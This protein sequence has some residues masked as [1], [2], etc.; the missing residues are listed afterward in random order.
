MYYLHNFLPSQPDLNFHQPQVRAAILAV[1][2]FWLERGV[3]GFRLDVINYLA[4]DPAL[5]DNP[6][7]G[8]AETPARTYLFQR[9]LHEKSQPGALAFAQSL[10]ALTD[11]YPDRMM[12][13]EIF[14]DDE[15]ALQRAFTE[16]ERRLHTAYSFHLL[17]ERRAEPALF[18]EAL[19][20]WRDASGWP[21]WSIGNHDVPRYP[22]RLGGQGAGEAQV[23]AL[24]AALFCLR[25]TLFLYQGDELGLPQGKVAFDDLRDPFARSA[26]TGDAGRD[27][28]R[29]PFPWTAETPM[30]GF[31]TAARA[32]LPADPAHAVRAVSTQV[33][34]PTST[35]SFCRRL[36][37][38]RRAEPAL[39]LGAAEVWPDPAG[40]LAVARIEEDSRVLCAVNLSDAPALL[41]VPRLADGV[42]LLAE[43]GAGLE[44]GELTLPAFGVAFVSL[45][46]P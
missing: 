45:R 28:A 12:V 41:A 9:H 31:T 34:D 32:W 24:L 23:K 26:F 39:R 1:A 25:G 27:G 3:D 15:L 21:S 8:G 19:E 29:T 10:R 36:I 38:L 42:V 17:A 13:G 30:A 22:T 4:H 37:A 43:P 11:R 7:V 6:P 40:V 20:A 44:H 46:S 35:L 33:G 2:R 18:I 14:D 16:G 5:P